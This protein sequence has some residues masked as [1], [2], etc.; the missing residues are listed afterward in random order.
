M[1]S[2]VIE[3]LLKD[4]ND[5]LPRIITYARDVPLVD[6]LADEDATQWISPEITDLDDP[7]KLEV[8]RLRYQMDVDELTYLGNETAGYHGLLNWPGAPTVT[9]IESYSTVE[10]ISTLS[11]ALVHVPNVVLVSVVAYGQMLAS[12]TL[13]DL[14]RGLAEAVN[15]P[16]SVRPC[17]WIDYNKPC[18]FAAYNDQHV[19]RRLSPPQFFDVNVVSCKMG[20]LRVDQGAVGY[21]KIERN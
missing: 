21:V 10:L 9:A 1:T 5:P 17:K 19:A 3:Q 13:Q 15:Q 12:S 18:D 2:P 6:E 4:M 20:Q 14:E 8:L 7:Q 11:G 16:V